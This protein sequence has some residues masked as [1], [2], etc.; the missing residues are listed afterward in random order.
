MEH[1]KI[2]SVLFRKDLNDLDE[3]IN[4]LRLHNM[5][6]YKVDE[7]KHYYR[8]RQVPPRTNS[9]RIFQFTHFTTKTIDKKKGI[10]FIIGWI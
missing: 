4:W 6:Y 3:C 5:N 9:N 7:A 8:F 2:Q 10:Q 1:S